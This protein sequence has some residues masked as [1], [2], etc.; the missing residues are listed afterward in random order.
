M[1][2]NK[3][4]VICEGEFNTLAYLTRAGVQP[5][6][7][8]FEPL[9]VKSYLPYIGENDTILLVLTGFVDFTFTEVDRLITY[10]SKTPTK[11]IFIFSPFKMDFV[12]EKYY[13][14]SGDLLTC[15]LTVING[16]EDEAVNLKKKQKKENNATVLNFFALIETTS[17]FRYETDV[18]YTIVERLHSEPVEEMSLRKLRYWREL[19]SV[20]LFGEG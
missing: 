15:D 20:N 18:D 12:T 17:P 8:Y 3:L 11:N 2:K 14:Y 6:K 1:A 4:V 10:I 5:T 16:E 19:K 7:V 9:T 13:V